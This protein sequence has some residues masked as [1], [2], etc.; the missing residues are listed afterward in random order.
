AKGRKTRTWMSVPS[1]ELFACAGVWRASDEWGDCYSM[2]MTDSAGPA[3]EVH[4]RMPV[5][6]R[7]EDYAGWVSGSPSD[8]FDLCRAWEGDLIVDR[9][10][11]PWAGG[12]VSQRSLF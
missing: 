7:Q 6:L 2:V 5:L 10:E 3:S 8:A 12:L 1:S 11:E 4:S 9:T